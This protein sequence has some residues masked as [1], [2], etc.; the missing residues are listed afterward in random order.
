MQKHL[1]VA[2]SHPDQL[3]TIGFG[4]I[5]PTVPNDYQQ[6]KRRNRRAALGMT[7]R[8]SADGTNWI[9]HWSS[10]AGPMPHWIDL[11]LCARGA[12]EAT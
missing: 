6:N 10:L 3:A 5:H 1:V 7:E 8:K 4:E 9:D 2:G 11:R 12:L